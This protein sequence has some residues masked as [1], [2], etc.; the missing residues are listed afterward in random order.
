MPVQ[1]R[2]RPVFLSPLTVLLASAIPLLALG[3]AHTA[4]KSEPPAASADN[5]ELASLRRENA[6]LRS[7]VQNLEER[8]RMVERGESVALGP[9]GDGYQRYGSLPTEPHG[10]WDE[11]EGDGPRQLPVVKLTPS[12][13]SIERREQAPAP[14]P[15]SATRGRSS[16]SLS[17]VPHS[18]YDDSDDYDSYDNYV[19]ARGG[20]DDRSEQASGA[21]ASYRLVGSKLVQAT[22]RKPVQATTSRDRDKGVVKSYEA[23]MALYKDGR[24]SEAEQAF[25]A[26]VSAH[27]NHEYADNALYW[28]GEAAY[29]Q[30]HY[31]DALAS[32]TKVVERYGGG[33]KAPDALLKIGLCY[34]R[35]GDA[36]N[37]RDVLTQLIAAYPSANASKIAKRK[38]AELDD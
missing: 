35:L 27:P 13:K 33:N 22:Q 15:T 18:G 12:G 31:A 2:S 37:A 10:E 11:P 7:R 29:D 38:L 17:A 20:Y 28:Q 36:A 32:F 8:L 25:A 5:P 14:Q 4:A 6:A 19:D 3:C 24:Y 34:G 1:L 16:I 21:P 23:A 9:S 30:A 26:I